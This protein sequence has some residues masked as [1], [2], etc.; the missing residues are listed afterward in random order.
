MID[1]DMIERADEIMRTFQKE[2]YNLC[3]KNISPTEVTTSYMVAGILM[4]TAIEIYVSTLD[5]EAVMK[6]VD[7]IKDTVPLV[8]E[9]MQRELGEVT[10]H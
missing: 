6:V 1:M 5:E 10:Y 7:A 9:K 8:A 4:K 2:V 3:E